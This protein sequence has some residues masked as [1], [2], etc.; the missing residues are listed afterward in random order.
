[1]QLTLHNST[2]SKLPVGNGLVL[3]P[4]D[5]EL[6]PEQLEQWKGLRAKGT[7]RQ[8]IK[9][10]VPRWPPSVQNLFNAGYLKVTKATS[11]Q[12]AKKAKASLSKAPSKPTKSK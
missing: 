11:G 7:S 2:K 12:A 8:L 4:G 5:N 3:E 1:M 6:T 10:K 9:D